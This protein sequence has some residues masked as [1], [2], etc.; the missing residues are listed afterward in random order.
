MYGVV[1]NHDGKEEWN[2]NEKSDEAIIFKQYWFKK[3]NRQ[4]IWVSTIFKPMTMWFWS[5]V[6]PSYTGEL[7][8]S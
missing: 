6:L 4:N 2:V 7:V 5:N 8:N 1:L 3:K